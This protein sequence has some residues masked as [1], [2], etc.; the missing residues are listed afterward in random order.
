MTHVF[1]LM[2]LMQQA[3]GDALIVD[4]YAAGFWIVRKLHP[5][6]SSVIKV[7]TGRAL[8]R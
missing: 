1:S 5:F 8:W 7:P 2:T 6:S 4:C 3:R